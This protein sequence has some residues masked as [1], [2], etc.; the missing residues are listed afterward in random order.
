MIPVKNIYYMLSYAFRLLREDG[1]QKVGTEDFDNTAELFAAILIHGITLQIKRG[2]VHEYIEESDSL[3]SPKGKIDI[4]KTIRSQSLIKKKI[5]CTYDEFSVDACMNQIIKSTILLLL[6][7]DISTSRRKKL[8]HLLR[9]F[10]DV[11]KIDL[12]RID[13]HFRYSRNNQS[14][15]L[16]ISICNLLCHG[17]IQTQECGSLK[18]MNFEDSQ[19]MHTLY[20]KFLLAY[21]QQTFPQLRASASYIPWQLDNDMDALLPSM[22]TDITL[23]YEGKALIIDAKYYGS[24]ILQSQFEKK[25]V[26]AGHLYQIFAY[27]KNKAA[28][29]KECPQNV[30]GLLLYAGTDEDV[31]PNQ[32]YSMSGNLISVE[33]LDLNQNFAKIKTHL[34]RIAEEYFDIRK[35]A[36]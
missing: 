16:L 23:S 5:V 36:I 17:L 13:W 20:E 27:V 19:E 3:S 24:G 25:S 33:T 11:E 9:Y 31:T 4:T 26:R 14:Y 1:Y 28:A 29:M 22:Q 15:R 35:A 21:Y 30:A 6:K 32:T 8:R 7:Y 34:D 12:K 2:L 18:L 10:A